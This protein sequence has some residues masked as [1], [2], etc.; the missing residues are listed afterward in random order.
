MLLQL[1]ITVIRVAGILLGCFIF[2]PS[3]LDLF[4]VLPHSNETPPFAARLGRNLPFLIFSPA[5]VVPYRR[6][7]TP[8]ARWAMTGAMIAIAAWALY[9]TVTGWQDYTAGQKSWEVIP[10]SIV[11]CAVVAGNIF[12]FSSL[13]PRSQKV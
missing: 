10:A 1:L 4:G 6:I 13:A 7:T 12:A 8:T 9:L 3:V 5:L 11:L 2:V